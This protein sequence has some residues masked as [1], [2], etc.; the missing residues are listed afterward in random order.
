MPV[1][2]H[3]HAAGSGGAAVRAAKSSVVAAGRSIVAPQA[4]AAAAKRKPSEPQGLPKSPRVEEAG[5]AF[6]E[7]AVCSAAAS[8]KAEEEQVDAELRECVLKVFKWC[9]AD[10]DGLLNSVEF[11]V[12][13]RIV[14]ELCPDDYNDAAAEATL[15]KAHGGSTS[16]HIDEIAFLDTMQTILHSLPISRRALLDGL[17]AV[18]S[19]KATA[20]D[21]SV[22][23][24]KQVLVRNVSTLPED[25]GDAAPPPLKLWRTATGKHQFP[26]PPGVLGGPPATLVAFKVMQYLAIRTED[27]TVIDDRLVSQMMGHRPM[28]QNM[29]DMIGDVRGAQLMSPE[30]SR[31]VDVDLFMTKSLDGEQIFRITFKRMQLSPAHTTPRLI[32]LGGFEP[33]PIDVSD[34]PPKLWAEMTSTPRPGQPDLSA[35]GQSSLPQPSLVRNTSLLGDTDLQ[36]LNL[37]LTSVP[38]GRHKFRLKFNLMDSGRPAAPNYLLVVPRLKTAKGHARYGDH[39]VRLF[40]EGA[41]APLEPAEFDSFIAADI[42]PSQLPSLVVEHAYT[43]CR[44]RVQPKNAARRSDVVSAQELTP[45]ERINNLADDPD[46]AEQLRALLDSKGLGRRSGERDIAYAVRLGRELGKDYKFDA[47]ITEANVKDL[48]RLIWASKRGDCSAFNAGFVYALRA[49]GIPA[50]VSLGLKYGKAIQQACGSVVAPHAQAAFFAEGIG[51]VPCDATLGIK[52]LG[53]EATGVI[54]FVE[55]QTGTLSLEDAEDLAKLIARPG[56]AASTCKSLQE[57]LEEASTAAKMD[58]N[59]LGTALSKI[60]KMPK[61]KALSLCTHILT[62]AGIGADALVSAAAYGRYQAAFDLGLFTELGAGNALVSAA[63][64][65]AKFYEGGPWKGVPIEQRQ[66]KENQSVQDNI[67]QVLDTV[68]GQ[69]GLDWASMWPHGV[70]SC[71]HTFEESAPASL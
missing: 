6:E 65:G 44:V 1:V 46:Q 23:D 11:G 67:D 35:L 36:S 40:L 54:S 42:R 25:V 15:Q 21:R 58:R 30:A 32:G 47:E 3:V 61:D 24:F 20:F 62:L 5:C 38:V 8:R 68:G 69:R 45:E 18:T 70:F 27:A 13:Q 56:D 63:K 33:S 26:L 17:A 12:A 37:V 16:G 31:T 60:K 53:H 22:A 51:W 71:S 28:F 9:D 48:R 57:Q 14:A 50:R 55:W 43:S 7:K 49:F 39:E 52:R 41:A 19:G 66:L 64:A 10:G 59:Q 29:V 34:V 4:K 2:K